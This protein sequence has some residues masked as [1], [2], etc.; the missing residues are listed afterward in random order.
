MFRF[1]ITLLSSVSKISCVREKLK[2]FS[3]GRL[4]G[5]P[6]SHIVSVFCQTNIGEGVS[7][8]KNAKELVL[9]S[10]SK[11]VYYHILPWKIYLWT[12]H[13]YHIFVSCVFLL[14]ERYVWYYINLIEID[15]FSTV[16]F[17]HDCFGQSKPLEIDNSEWW[18]T[19]KQVER[20]FQ[21]L[22]QNNL[23]WSASELL[24][25]IGHLSTTRKRNS[26]L[27]IKT[28]PFLLL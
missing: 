25:D 22:S 24:P 15:F 21:P 17:S 27:N 9:T 8:L 23:S 10:F 6:W 5:R 28:W 7:E 12:G 13:M 20:L 2:S 3:S 4:G 26:K 1:Q 11:Y 19:R 14:F 16:H 18:L